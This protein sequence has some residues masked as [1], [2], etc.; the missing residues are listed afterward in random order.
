MPAL[1]EYIYTMF[2]MYTLLIMEDGQGFRK[3]QEDCHNSPVDLFV[4]RDSQYVQLQ[5]YKLLWWAVDSVNWYIIFTKLAF[6]YLC[7]CMYIYLILNFQTFSCSGKT[8]SGTATPL[9]T[10]KRTP[11]GDVT[12][13]VSK[14][15]SVAKPVYSQITPAQT[16]VH[17][18][19]RR[20]S[21]K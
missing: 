17:K 16:P 10:P 7:L 18:T 4:Y 8:I 12:R 11:L 9:K 14:R 2:Q 3:V 21:T 5:R 1:F 13:S 19:P 20:K 6:I 15:K